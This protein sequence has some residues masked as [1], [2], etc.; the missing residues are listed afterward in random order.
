[1]VNVMK[2]MADHRLDAIAHKTV[3]HQPTLISQG[4]GP[5]YYDMHGATHINT[6]LVHVPSVSVPAGWTSQGLPVGMT[7]LGRPFDDGTMIKLAYGYEQ[8]TGH[9]I[10]PTTTP[11][12]PGEP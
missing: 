8:A 5:P 1:M 9:R 3:E 7:F 4:V 2:V 10:P 12:L 6:F 11:G